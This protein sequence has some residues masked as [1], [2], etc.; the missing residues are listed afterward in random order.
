MSRWLL[1]KS[2]ERGQGPV[3]GPRTWEKK[4]TTTMT[5]TRRRRRKRKRSGE[6]HRAERGPP[7]QDVQPAPRH[8]L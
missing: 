3:H 5:T 7:S 6:R 1:V 4:M 8:P 2:S